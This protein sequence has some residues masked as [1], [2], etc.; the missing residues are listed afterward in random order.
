MLYQRPSSPFWWYC[1]DVDK[2]RY[3]GSTKETNKRKAEGVEARIRTEV[4]DQKMANKLNGFTCEIT[5]ED[6]GKLWFQ[7]EGRVQ[8]SSKDN[9][10]RLRKLL[11]KMVVDNAVVP[12][13]DGSQHLHTLRQRDVQALYDSRITSGNA[14][15]T[16]NRE[17]SLFQ[18][19]CS[20]AAK[21]G[22]MVPSWRDRIKDIKTREPKG[23]TRYLLPEEEAALLNELEPRDDPRR[24]AQYDIVVCL[25][26]TGAR[27]NE[28]ASLTWDAVDLSIGTFVLHR[29]KVKNATTLTM[30]ERMRRCLAA[31]YESRDRRSPYVFPG[32][33]P[34]KHR[35]H[36]TK[37]I[38]QAMERVGINSPPKVIREGKATVHTLR[39][40]FASKLV[41]AGVSLYIVQEILGHST[42]AMTQKY[43]H[44]ETSDASKA[45]VAVLDK[46]NKGELNV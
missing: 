31:R 21:R 33:V 6:A 41:K 42:P 3:R 22:F 15:G 38:M 40:T 1:F 37:G 44:L 4:A 30:S 16:A 18:A 20:F 8:R 23:K 25:L 9:E 12:G 45:A 2:R 46:L 36:A 27:Y 5:L 28:I 32:D 34:S 29:S 17:L 7:T 26:D 39:D 13:L 19:I 35:T 14:V 10:S 43:A 11:G 24:A